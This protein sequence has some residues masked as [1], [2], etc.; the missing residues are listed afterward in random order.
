MSASEWNTVERSRQ[1]RNY[2][3][4]RTVARA[5]MWGSSAMFMVGINVTLLY[6]LL[7]LTSIIE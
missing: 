5:A 4:T 6:A 2:G 3:V 7:F 1:P